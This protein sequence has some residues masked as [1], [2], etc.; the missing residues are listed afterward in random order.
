M[1]P[2]P[3]SDNDVVRQLSVRIVELEQRLAE[4]E[5]AQRYFVLHWEDDLRYFHDAY[6]YIPRRH[7]TPEQINVLYANDGMIHL[8]EARKAWI[9]FIE[10]ILRL[11][12]TISTGQMTE[13]PFARFFHVKTSVAHRW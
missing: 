6:H 8:R 13:T 11:P 3:P 4:A 9:A 7:L 10:P 1:D 5:A 12:G 2:P